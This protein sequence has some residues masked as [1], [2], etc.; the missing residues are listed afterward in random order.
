MKWMWA[1]VESC[2][3]GLALLPSGASGSEKPHFALLRVFV[4]VCG[5]DFFVY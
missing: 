5:M 3:Q 2:A 4:G 1:D